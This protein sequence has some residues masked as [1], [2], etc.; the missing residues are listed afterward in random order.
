MT[1]LPPWQILLNY[2]KIGL[3]PMADPHNDDEIALFAPDPRCIIPL[4]DFHVSKSLQRTIRTERFE[5]RLDHDFRGIMEA[6]A[7]PA[8]GRE[9]T[10]LSP[11]LM[12]IY[13][14]LHRQGYAHSVECWLDNELAGGLYGVSI[15]GL[16]AGES[17][18]HR[19]R[20]ASKVALAHLVETMRASGYTL[21]DVQYH[22]DHLGTFGAIEVSRRKYEKLLESALQQNAA[23]PAQLPT[24][25]IGES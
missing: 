5:I 9:D 24:A 2:Y 15:G 16:F 7:A 6:C 14:E 13:E 25:P 23:W 12:D 21:L 22:T 11:E 17:M 1:Q 20:D 10:W 3:F 19:V 8:P 4:D 18:F